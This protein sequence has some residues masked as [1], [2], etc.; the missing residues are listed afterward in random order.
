MIFKRIFY[1][2]C[3]V[4]ILWLLYS[5]SQKE[6]PQPEKTGGVANTEAK[7]SISDSLIAKTTKLLIHQ[8]IDHV[9]IEKWK[10][11]AIE[12]IKK[13][14]DRSYHREIGKIFGDIE[15][16]NIKDTFGLTRNSSREE[17]IKIIET[18]DKDILFKKLDEVPDQ[19]IARLIKK[20][21]G[22]QTISSIKRLKDF[23][24]YKI[25]RITK[26]TSG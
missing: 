5:Y 26:P 22:N 3:A 6:A 9:D 13:K 8:A 12:N 18:T 7:I 21:F 23:V 2:L 19:A 25:Y 24:D 15:Y 11:D 17:V 4:V 1:T 16:M 10:K 20:K 14:S